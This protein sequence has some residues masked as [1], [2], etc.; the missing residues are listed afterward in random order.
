[1]CRNACDEIS[2]GCSY[3][4]T[5]F[6]NDLPC[7]YR[8][9]SAKSHYHASCYKSYTVKRIIVL[10]VI[11]NFKATQLESFKEVVTYMHVEV[12]TV[13][14]VRYTDMLSKMRDSM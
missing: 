8:F 13:S 4:Q 2:I 10:R 3:G 5:R 12:E 7:I 1:M 6:W 9:D 14:I 11:E